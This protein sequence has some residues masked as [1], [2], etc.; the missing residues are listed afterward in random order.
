MF[1]KP[2]NTRL[3]L[4]SCLCSFVAGGLLV[5]LLSSLFSLSPDDRSS[6]L[7]RANQLAHDQGYAEALEHSPQVAVEQNAI[8]ILSNATFFDSIEVEVKGISRQ[9]NAVELTY[10]EVGRDRFR[11][12]SL[13][14]GEAMAHRFGNTW[15]VIKHV[16]VFANLRKATLEVTKVSIPH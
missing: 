2:Q 12:P 9:S 6:E 10:G 7:A 14:V 4:L 3:W 5:A 13:R 11:I 8:G 16:S 1:E 15:Y